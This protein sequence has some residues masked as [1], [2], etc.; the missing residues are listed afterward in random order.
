MVLKRIGLTGASG[1]LGAHLLS[2][3]AQDG[4]ATLATSR[5]RPVNLPAGAIW[6]SWDLREW[7]TPAEL[8]DGNASFA[9]ANAKRNED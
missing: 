2:R 5:R 9:L 6:T 7:R 8:D 4:V 3:L 1:M